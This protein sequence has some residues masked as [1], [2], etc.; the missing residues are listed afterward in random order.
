M[1]FGG[2]REQG[3]RIKQAAIVRSI[4]GPNGLP[5]KNFILARVDYMVAWDKNG[6]VRTIG[7]NVEKKIISNVWYN[8][9]QVPLNKQTLYLGDI[10]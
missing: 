3:K 7:Y 9:K 5:V 8:E 1:I 2:A 4:V 6:E 10:K